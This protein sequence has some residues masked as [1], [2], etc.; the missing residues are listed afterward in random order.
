MP[1]NPWGPV[2]SFGSVHRDSPGLLRENGWT[3]VYQ[4]LLDG[5]DGASR[6]ICSGT[7]DS[8][9]GY[10]VLP[11]LTEGQTLNIFSIQGGSGNTGQPLQFG[12]NASGDGTYAAP[13]TDGELLMVGTSNANGPWFQ[14]YELPIKIHGPA[15]VW[16]EGL[17][18]GAVTAYNYVTM[19]YIIVDESAS[20]IS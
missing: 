15:K 8:G 2:S 6:A 12:L 18:T 5:A 11:I 4:V 3:T 20:V 10:D 13:K 1:V 16:W 19:N 9:T 14:G 17:E 7:G